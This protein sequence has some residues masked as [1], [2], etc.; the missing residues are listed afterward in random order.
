M[1]G[2]VILLESE[3]HREAQS[4]LPWYAAGSLDAADAAKVETH[5]AACSE[6]AADLRLERRLRPELSALPPTPGLGVDHGW[7]AM[8]RALE[9]EGG[10]AVAREGL[11]ARVRAA[12][13]IQPVWAGWALAGQACLVVALAT[14]TLWQGAQPARYVALSAGDEATAGSIVV[15]FAPDATER[16]LRA[17]IRAS[18]G[19]LIGGPTDADAYVIAAPPAGLPAALAALRSHPKVL[20]AEPLGV[21]APP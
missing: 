7:A 8:R 21:D 4:L 17:I 20:L 10:G 9:A 15:M 12:F 5:L 14:A 6:C 16:E 13:S 1:S 19:R 18:N 3:R 2:H 11:M